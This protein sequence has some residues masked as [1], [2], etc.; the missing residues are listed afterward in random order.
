ML[1]ESLRA[2]CKAPGG[3]ARVWKYLEALVR[4]TGVSGRCANGLQTDL[5]LVDVIMVMMVMVMIMMVTMVMVMM[6]MM[7]M[8]ILMVRVPKAH[9]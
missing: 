4:A 8:V 7:V 5:H 2:L 6:L 3:S 1:L 9:S